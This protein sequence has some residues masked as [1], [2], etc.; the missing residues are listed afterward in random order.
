MSGDI[1]SQPSIDISIS[2]A[3]QLQSTDPQRVLFIGQQTSAATAVSG[4]LQ[5]SIGNAESVA[6]G[7]FGITSMLAGMIRAAKII[8]GQT[9][10]DAIGLDDAAG[11]NATGT[12]VFAS[13]PTTEAGTYTVTVGS[14]RNH[15][16]DIAV[17]D[18]DTITEIGDALD[19]LIAADTKAPFTSSNSAGTVTITYI[20]DGTVG[21][22]MTLKVEGVIAGVTHSITAMTGGATDPTLT[23]LFDV[24]DGERYRHVIWPSEYGYT[25]ATDEFDP[26]FNKTDEIQDGVVIA[27]ETDTLANLKTTGGAENSL[28]LTVF[29]NQTVNDTSYKGSAILEF[30]HVI[31]AEFVAT[32]SLRFTPGASIARYVISTTGLADNFGGVALNSK[33]Y[34]NTPFFE[35]PIIPIG[36]GFTNVEIEELNDAGISV[37]GNN[38]A[39]NTIIAGEVLTTR[40]TDAS[41]NPETTFKFLNN[42]DVAVTVRELMHNNLQAQYA[43][44]R[45]TEGDLVPNRSMANQGSIEAFIDGLYQTFSGEDFVLTQAGST[46]LDFFKQNRTVTLDL[47]AGKATVTMQVPIVV[48]FREIVVAMQITFSTE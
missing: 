12:I 4:V 21:N 32:R 1:I 25:V 28:S 27:S 2:P 34:F 38:S 6:N 18:G 8:N 9:R 20:H 19:V 45:L 44:S 5:E 7:L 10:F 14:D 26:R 16:Y 41:A 43:Q 23:T 35:L 42:V 46:A 39:R 15:K 22:N 17:A 31:A 24:I 40:K 33:P 47:T 37:L 36:K 3:Q 13:G 48:Q 30:D 11:T 29:G